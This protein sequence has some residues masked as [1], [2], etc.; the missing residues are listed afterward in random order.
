MT[1][2]KPFTNKLLL[3]QDTSLLSLTH[4]LWCKCLIFLIAENSMNKYLSFYISITSF[5]ESPETHFLSS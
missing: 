2:I 4:S 3:I 1:T 5:K